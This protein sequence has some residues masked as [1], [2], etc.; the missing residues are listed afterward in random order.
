MTSRSFF[1]AGSV[2]C[3]AMLITASCSKRTTVKAIPRAPQA[4]VRPVRI[5]DVEYGI[6]SWYGEPYHGRNSANGERY[7]MHSLTAAHRTMPFGTWVR[8]D[9][10]T[11]RK[12]VAV[13]ITDRGPF[14]GDRIIDLSRKAAEQISMIGPGTAPVKLTVIEP[15][16]GQVVEQYGVQLAAWADR[17]KAE[18]LQQKL[19]REFGMARL[20]EK[21]GDPVLYRVIAGA[22]TREQAEALL[23]RLRKAGYRGFVTRHVP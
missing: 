4:S 20:V 15:P 9:N 23:L 7:D 21:Q 2:A 13:R 16:A 18:E 22:G 12:S 6:A 17:G 8:V 3:L 10:Q 1:H 11:N 5:G 14:V 19:E